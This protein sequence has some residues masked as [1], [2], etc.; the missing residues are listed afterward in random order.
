V[1]ACGSAAPNSFRHLPADP[2]IEAP[3]SQTALG[4]E[5]VFPTHHACRPDG[6]TRFP[7]MRW[8]RH[9]EP[10]T[11]TTPS[12]EEFAYRGAQRWHFS[13]LRRRF[14]CS[15]FTRRFAYIQFEAELLRSLAASAPRLRPWL[16]S[17]R[18]LASL[19]W[20]TATAHQ[21]ELSTRDLALLL[22]FSLAV[23]T[24]CLFSPGFWPISD[25]SNGRCV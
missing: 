12:R 24:Y 7:R 14:W 13:P 20:P 21:L 15:T 6:L 22:P 5:S 17:S 10:T 18:R 3:S 19:A 16:L 9:A 1:N 2:R 23:L 11:H 4:N 25:L 8:S